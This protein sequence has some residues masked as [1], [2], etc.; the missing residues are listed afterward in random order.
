MRWIPFVILIYVALL[1]QVVVAA[2]PVRFGFTGDIAPDIPAI[3]AVFF[4]LSVRDLHDAMLAAW[5][6]GLAM[7]IMLC[8]M[9]GIVT[10]VGP[11]PIA[12]ALGSGIIYRVR[13]AFF[14]DRALARAILTL[15]F[16]LTAHFLWVTIQT[17]LV[18]AWSAW[19][20]AVAKAIGISIYT[21]AVAPLV[22]VVLQRCGGWFIATPARR[23]R[24]R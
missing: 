4:A 14:R 3:L 20:S 11:M 16:C 24:R 12:Y 6:L 21:A 19:W 2:L 15:V 9:G 18:L 1:V 7:D 17:L 23:S 13:E 5:S 8:G 10:A 22:C